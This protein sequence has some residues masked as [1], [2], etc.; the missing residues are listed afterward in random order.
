M[1]GI[2]AHQ[3]F[4]NWKAWVL[5]TLRTIIL[6]FSHTFS[7]RQFD[8]VYTC[9]MAIRATLSPIITISIYNLIALSVSLTLFLAYYNAIICQGS[10]RFFRFEASLQAEHPRTATTPTKLNTTC[11]HNSSYLCT[12]ENEMLKLTWYTASS[13]KWCT[14]PTLA[15]NNYV[16]GFPLQRLI[17]RG[18]PTCFSLNKKC[19]RD[20]SV[21]MQLRAE[22]KMGAYHRLLSSAVSPPKPK[23]YTVRTSLVILSLISFSLASFISWQ[24]S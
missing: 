5:F 11:N 4:L 14:I 24:D 12:N 20:I 13:Q 6:S 23:W 8:L 2:Q 3:E 21:L 9:Y 10:E 7:Y 22:S 1:G 19:E 17:W 18:R 16:T 15:Q